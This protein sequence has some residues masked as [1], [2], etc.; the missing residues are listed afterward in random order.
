MI[1]YNGTDSISCFY[2]FHQSYR[3]RVQNNA[4]LPHVTPLPMMSSIVVAWLPKRT[5]M[6]MYCNQYIRLHPTEE[7]FSIMTA[8]GS[9][10]LRLLVTL[11]ASITLL[12]FA[13]SYHLQATVRNDDKLPST[14]PPA[15]LL[16]IF[17]HSISNTSYTST[18]YS[19]SEP[20]LPVETISAPS[21]YHISHIMQKPPS[22]LWYRPLAPVQPTPA[23]CCLRANSLHSWA[24]WRQH[25]AM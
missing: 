19:H 12:V 11:A 5:F 23:R 4:K 21:W 6:W 25:T 22:H 14:R 3:E 24:G 17:S 9:R 15:L 7:S 2:Y 8:S 16:I 18:Y 10:Q 20:L 1:L 13:F